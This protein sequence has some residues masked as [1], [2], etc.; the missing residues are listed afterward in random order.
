VVR[1]IIPLGQQAGAGNLVVCEIIQAH[2]LAHI[3]DDNSE[4]I[5]EKIDLVA[6]LGGDYY[7]RIAAPNIFK[8]PKP[9]T[10]KGIGI[11]A[12]PTHI[13][14]SN[15]L[16]GNDLGKMGN[17]THLPLPAE[18]THCKKKYTNHTSQQLLEQNLAFEAVCLLM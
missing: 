8:V 18:I 4:I 16:T 15:A 5:P 2:F 1:Q 6:R 7:A 9:L 17:I 10:T 11:D 3:F 13:K 12:L 14:N